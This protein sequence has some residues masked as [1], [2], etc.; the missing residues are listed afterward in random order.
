MEFK[1]NLR[2]TLAQVNLEWENPGQNRLNLEGMI[3]Q[4]TGHSDLVILPETF[5]T[6]FSMRIEELAEP[7]EGTTIKWLLNLSEKANLAI[8]GSLLIREYDRYYNRFVFIA[9]DG[10][11]SWYNKRHLFS[12]GGESDRMTSGNKRAIVNYLGWRIA[13]YVCYDLRF[14]VWCRNVGDTDLMIFTA[15]WPET[16]SEVWCTLLRARAI[17]NQAYVAGVNR[18]GT[19][20]NGI[21][22]I[23]ES[24][25]INARGEVIESIRLSTTK[26]QTITISKKELDDFREKFP[27]CRDADSFIIS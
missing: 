7:M 15:N 14:P 2:V 9:P 26:L 13:L 21:T 3:M 18:I 23:G 6:G 25:I 22:Y 10:V 17:E 24:Q 12:I 4:L 27:V 20:G 5:T 11:I 19:D 16:R 1:D 8:C